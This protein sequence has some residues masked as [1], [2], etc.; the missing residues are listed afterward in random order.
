MRGGWGRGPLFRGHGRFGGHH[1]RRFRIRHRLPGCL[2][3]LVPLAILVALA[4]AV[5][6]LVGRRAPPRRLPRIE[7]RGGSESIWL[8]R[9]SPP[10]RA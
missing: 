9:A 3:C 10:A 6:S 4:A 5:L 1:R 7:D 2:G 8:G